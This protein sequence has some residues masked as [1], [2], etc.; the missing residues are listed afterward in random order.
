MSKLVVVN[1]ATTKCS[2]SEQS[3]FLLVLP[4]LR[5]EVDGA[6]PATVDDHEPGINIVPFGECKYLGGQQCVP[7]TPSPWDK[8][9]FSVPF[10][11]YPSLHMES[12]LKCNAGGTIRLRSSGQGRPF[13]SVDN[14]SLSLAARL[15]RGAYYDR[16]LEE[17]QKLNDLIEWLDRPDVIGNT[18]L[19]TVKEFSGY[20]DLG[21]AL[22]AAKR[23]EIGRALFNL[24]MAVPWS[25][26]AKLRHVPKA[27]RA[28]RRGR[29]GAGGLKI[30]AGQQGKHIR[31]HNNYV[32]R[33][34]RSVLTKDPSELARRAGTGHPVNKVPRGQPGFKERVDF[35]EVIGEYINPATGIAVPTTKGIIH[36][37]KN[38]IHIVPARP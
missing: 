11:L 23:D 6:Y 19:E 2:G 8:G 32:P 15:Q 33:R 18:L 37:G 14:D 25:K 31:G 12:H 34:R 5:I 17:Q 24:G 13:F 21:R 7:D 38:G 4:V 27:L 16:W 10:G 30:H 9:V 22:D 35:G 29:K 1:G 28:L 20:N 36:Y 26:V 3:S